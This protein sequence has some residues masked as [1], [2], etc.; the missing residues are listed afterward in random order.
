MMIYTSCVSIKCVPSPHFIITW[1]PP[2][3]CHFTE[4]MII[5]HSY[6]CGTV[7]RDTFVLIPMSS[8]FASL[9]GI[10]N[11]MAEGGV[12]GNRYLPLS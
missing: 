6:S 4:L 8:S 3:I 7:C 9:K 2:H 12:R 11:Q 10:T 1:S 5:L